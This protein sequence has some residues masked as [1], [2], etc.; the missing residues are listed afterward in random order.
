[1]PLKTVIVYILS[2]S[3]C[4]ILVN[5]KTLKKCKRLQDNTE[6]GFPHRLCMCVF[7]VL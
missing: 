3:I 5:I 4:H 1:M 2:I 6:R 7:P